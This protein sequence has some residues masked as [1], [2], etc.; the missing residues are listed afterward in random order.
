MIFRSS[1]ATISDWANDWQLPISGTKSYWMYIANTLADKDTFSFYMANSDIAETNLIKD[2]GVKFDSH[3]KFSGHIT[4]IIGKA[5]SKV[6]LI[7]KTF[8]SKDPHT[9]IKAFVTY[10]LPSLEYCSAVW[11]PQCLT[12]INK[13]ESVQRMFTK[14]LKG[15]QNLTYAER[16]EKSGLC[17]LELRRLKADLVLCYKILHDAVNIDQHNLF[18]I[19]PS[20]LTRGHGLKLRSKRPR[21]DTRKSFYGYRVVSVWNHLNPSTVWAAS[22]QSFKNLLDSEDLSQF[23]LTDH[24][25]FQAE[26]N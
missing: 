22:L 10:V 1:L 19:E 20:G 11:S 21:L 23:L 25:S 17:S 9:I 14:R 6:F 12:D 3:L 7:N 18:S 8:I 5:R 15:F 2:L 26:F 24:D 13:I 4:D 16:L